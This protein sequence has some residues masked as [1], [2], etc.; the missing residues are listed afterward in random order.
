MF[1]FHRQH[2]GHFSALTN[3]FGSPGQNVEKR[4][5]HIHYGTYTN[6]KIEILFFPI[7]ILVFKVIPPKLQDILHLNLFYGLQVCMAQGGIGWVFGW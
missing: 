4:Y 5:D 1:V 7:D 3:N 2:T 6:P